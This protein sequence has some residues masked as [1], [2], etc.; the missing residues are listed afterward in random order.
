M[1]HAVKTVSA[2]NTN[3]HYMKALEQAGAVVVSNAFDWETA[4]K[5]D[6]HNTTL[7]E[8][9]KIPEHLG[10]AL[11]EHFPAMKINADIFSDF[12]LLCI[13]TRNLNMIEIVS[14]KIAQAHLHQ[15][16]RNENDMMES[17]AKDL[18]RRLAY[19]ERYQVDVPRP[20]ISHH[21]AKMLDSGNDDLRKRQ[22]M[23]DVTRASN[24]KLK[25]A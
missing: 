20:Q 21:L 23:V 1:E 10:K 3:A 25:I 15:H 6:G 8:W 18:E 2:F 4:R 7:E 24:A 12:E 11:H 19:I 16:M 14:H 9:N 22:D 17:A 5:Y 13:H